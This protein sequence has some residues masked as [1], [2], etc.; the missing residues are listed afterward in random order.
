MVRGILFQETIMTNEN[1]P[2]SNTS[3]I[4]APLGETVTFFAP[5]WVRLGARL[6]ASSLDSKLAVGVHPATNNLLAA[7]AQRLASTH[8]RRGLADSWLDLLIEVRRPRRPFDPVVP[9]VRSRVLAAEAQIRALADAVVSPLPTVHG[10][11]MAIEALRDGAGPLFNPSSPL[12]LSSS[13]EAIVAQLNPLTLA[14]SF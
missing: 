7:R 2:K 5:P 13:V 8:F 14:S 9:L 1:L 6:F 10:L 11:A 3:L 12:K 4:D